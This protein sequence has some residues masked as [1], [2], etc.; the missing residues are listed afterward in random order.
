MSEG[1]AGN[2]DPLGV[3]EG[4]VGKSGWRLA[5]VGVLKACSSDGV[6]GGSGTELG[7][8]TSDAE[9]QT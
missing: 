2:P 7:V 5:E 1:A 9:K 3:C 4:D 6:A 8:S